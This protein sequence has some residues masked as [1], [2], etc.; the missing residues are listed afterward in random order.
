[1]LHLSTYCQQ[2]GQYTKFDQ[3][4]LKIRTNEAEITKQTY[5]YNILNKIYIK[6]FWESPFHFE[7]SETD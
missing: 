3:A 7:V 6:L 4:L 5:W 1:M 2:I